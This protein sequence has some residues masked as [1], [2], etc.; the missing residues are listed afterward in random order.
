[1][2]GHA[3]T[4]RR[5]DDL[6]A[7]G[8][9]RVE[10]IFVDIPVETAVTRADARHREGQDDYHIGKGCGGRFLPDEVIL[11]QADPEWGS[12]NR[13]TFEAVKHR[14]DSWARYDNSAAAP[15]LEDAKDTEE[16]T[17]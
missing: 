13:R 11:A 6:R 16:G 3:S 17:A 4:E 10:G 1:M 9:G 7:A 14:F 12:L 15:V 2:S 8:Y 5:I